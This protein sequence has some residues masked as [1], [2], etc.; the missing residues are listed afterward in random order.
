MKQ[1]SPQLDLR[2]I[3]VF[4]D[5]LP[6]HDPIVIM[7]IGTVRL[8][9]RMIMDMRYNSNDRRK[10]ANVIDNVDLYPMMLDGIPR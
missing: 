1:K 4:Q 3:T 7:R 2:M 5:C 6:H 9:I 10:R 8:S